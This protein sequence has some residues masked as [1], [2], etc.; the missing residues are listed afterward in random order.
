MTK[1]QAFEMGLFFTAIGQAV[2]S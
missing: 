1:D 2:H